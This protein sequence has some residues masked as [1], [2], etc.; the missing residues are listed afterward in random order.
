MQHIYP[1]LFMLALLG[2]LGWLL[3]VTDHLDPRI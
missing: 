1:V 3:I 2:G